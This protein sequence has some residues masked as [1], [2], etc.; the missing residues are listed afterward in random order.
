MAL[1]GQELFTGRNL[2]SM[3]DVAPD[4]SGVLEMQWTGKAL[5][6]CLAD[7]I[8]QLMF[9]LRDHLRANVPKRQKERI[10]RALTALGIRPLI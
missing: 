4:L 9:E 8:P 10:R 1:P 2:F 7:F 6:V 5:R 3:K